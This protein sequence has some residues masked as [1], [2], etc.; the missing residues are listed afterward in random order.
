MSSTAINLILEKVN[1]YAPALRGLSGPAALCTHAC[2]VIFL[3]QI[4]SK[5]KDFRYMATSDLLNELSKSS[6]KVDSDLEKKL[7]SVIAVQL[8][9][10]S[11]DIS[12]LA[13]K[14]CAMRR[15]P[16]GPPPPP[17]PTHPLRPHASS[18]SA[19]VPAQHRLP[20]MAG[21]AALHVVTAPARSSTLGKSRSRCQ[22]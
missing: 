17:S 21:S 7:C 3:L 6:F 1:Y 11:G 12:G 4:A 2:F 19:A 20:C 5:D 15:G 10:T 22:A 18:H 16:G 9:D 14:W 8:E 13:V